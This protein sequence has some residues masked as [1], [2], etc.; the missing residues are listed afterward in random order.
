MKIFVF[1]TETTGF[2]NKK[3]PNL[4]SQPK[5]VQ[6]S[7]IMGELN[8]GEFIELERIDQYI[9][10]GI[11]IPFETSKIHHIYDIDVINAPK[12]DEVIDK[13]LYFINT[14]DVIVGHNVEFDEEMLKLEL[15]RLQREHDYRP[16]NVYCSMKN[17]VEFCAIMG[18]RDRLKYPKLGEL[19]KK[20]FGDYFIGAHNAIVDV[21]NTLK[22]F[23][24]LHKK[25]IVHIEEK[26]ETVM[27]LF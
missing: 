2:I 19:H 27:S 3:D 17:T 23:L 20:L 13:I 11:K 6:F 25:G 18:D 12:F 26:E 24:E 21:E 4:E 5:I 22:C 10:P 15:K 9:N 16:K 14:P 8:N 1:D 7:G